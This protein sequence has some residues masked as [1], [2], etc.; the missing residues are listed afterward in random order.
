MSLILRA[1]CANALLSYHS[2][3]LYQCRTAGVYHLIKK[4]FPPFPGLQRRKWPCTH[5]ASRHAHVHK[6][7]VEPTPPLH[8]TPTCA[9]LAV[10]EVSPG[11]PRSALS[12]EQPYGLLFKP[13][14]FFFFFLHNSSQE[15]AFYYTQMQPVL[16]AGALL[17]QRATATS[18]SRSELQGASPQGGRTGF[19]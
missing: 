18:L 15:V 12:H 11:I 7:R 16:D 10:S 17:G 9:L 3:V 2:I 6:V 19:Q 8:S 5:A 14:G 1:R 13:A 4:V